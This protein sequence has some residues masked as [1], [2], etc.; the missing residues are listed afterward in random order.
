MFIFHK[1]SCFIWFLLLLTHLVSHTHML[2]HTSTLWELA[3]FT[4]TIPPKGYVII[5]YDQVW[6]SYSQVVWNG[7]QPFKD[8]KHWW[9]VWCCN[10]FLWTSRYDLALRQLIK[11]YAIARY[12]P[13]QYLHLVDTSLKHRMYRQ[14]LL[15]RKGNQQTHPISNLKGSRSM[16]PIGKACHNIHKLHDISISYTQ[17]VSQ[18][19]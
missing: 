18:I 10:L 6:V 2:P 17:H 8:I 16:F 11:D 3:L 1:P 5:F 13:R 14:A 9:K 4:H 7:G 12:H 15:P 19:R